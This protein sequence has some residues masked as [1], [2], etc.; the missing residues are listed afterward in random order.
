MV[1]RRENTDASC[2]A[3]VDERPVVLL[4]PAQD[5]ARLDV[6]VG[7]AHAVQRGERAHAVTQRLHG[8]HA[9]MIGGAARSE[10]YWHSGC[11][12]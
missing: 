5:V 7:V 12:R 4:W 8:T 11:C 1:R 3:K 10:V 6:P 2:A 9:C